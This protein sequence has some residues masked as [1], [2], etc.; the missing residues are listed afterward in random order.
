MH[1]IVYNYAPTSLLSTWNSNANRDVN[2]RNNNDLSVPFSRTEN[3]KRH[4][5]FSLPNS[6]NALNDLRFQYNPTTFRIALHDHLADP[7][8]FHLTGNNYPPIR[9]INGNFD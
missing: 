5:Y 1:S 3:L 4:P 9:E 7:P 2:L 6:W 8:N